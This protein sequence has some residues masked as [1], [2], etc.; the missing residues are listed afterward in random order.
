MACFNDRPRWEFYLSR[1]I[2]EVCPGRCVPPTGAIHPI[3]QILGVS[4]D[5]QGPEAG[6]VYLVKQPMY[7]GVCFSS[8]SCPAVKY[9]K[10]G[11]RQ[12]HFLPGVRFP[13]LAVDKANKVYQIWL[14]HR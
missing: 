9:L 4:S 10:L 13:H 5:Y 2:G 3:R 12:G 8:S 7:P 1:A 6:M 14:R 11:P